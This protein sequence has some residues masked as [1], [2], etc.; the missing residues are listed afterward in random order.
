MYLLDTDVLIDI[1]RG[2]APAI[3][4]FANLPEVP[5]VPGFVVMEL[6][7]DARNMQQVRNALK[8]VAPLPVVW[9]T[10]ADCAPA[11]SDFTT[12]HLS[13]SLGLLDALIAACAVG[14]GATLC[15]FNVK[16]YRIVPG[17]MTAQ[18]YTR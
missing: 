3:A 17:L 10:E 14:R 12:Y 18:P 7:Q 8:L 6:I 9:A 13:N 1:Q 2:H 11:L 4:W 16:H 15:T 5:S